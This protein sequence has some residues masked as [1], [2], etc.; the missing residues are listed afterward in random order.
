MIGWW[1]I[2]MRNIYLLGF[3]FC[4]SAC[5]YN[6]PSPKQ[7]AYPIIKNSSFSNKINNIS[8]FSQ[9]NTAP[10]SY[11]KW[12]GQIEHQQQINAYKT[13]LKDKGLVFYIPDYQFLQTAKDWQKCHANEYEVP[14]QELWNNIIPTLNILN[15]LVEQQVIQNFTVTSVYRNNLL[16]QCAGG[17]GSSRHVFNAALDFRIGDQNPDAKQQIFIQ[18]TKL[19]LCQFWLDHG[20]ALQMGLGV[21][22]SGQIHIDAAGY[23]TW[24]VDHRYT[25]SP[26]MKDFS[27]SVLSRFNTMSKTE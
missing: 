13:F 21:Y 15:Q 8:N 12:S 4:V 19:K 1:C 3:I 7:M 27:N 17:A 18:E 10:S 6:T 25:S 2:D 14:H 20:E 9:Q 11:L 22:E 16:N 5:Q 26:C 24:G 23:R